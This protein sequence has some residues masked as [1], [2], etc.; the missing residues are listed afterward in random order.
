MKCRSLHIQKYMTEVP[1]TPIAAYVRVNRSRAV[2]QKILLL[3][4]LGL[5]GVVFVVVCISQFAYNATMTSPTDQTQEAVIIP[6]HSADTTTSGN[7]KKQHNTTTSTNSSTQD[8]TGITEHQH[9]IPSVHAASIAESVSSG[10]LPIMAQMVVSP[11]TYPYQDTRFDWLNPD[12]WQWAD[13]SDMG[14]GAAAKFKSDR[15]IVDRTI[16]KTPFRTRRGWSGR[17]IIYTEWIATPQSDTNIWMLNRKINPQFGQGN[18]WPYNGELDLF[19]M[20]TADTALQPHFDFSGFREFS[21][22]ASYGQ[23]TFHMGGKTDGH[24]CFCPASHSKQ[25]WYQNVPSMTSGCTAQFKNTPGQLNRLAAV[26][27]TDNEGQYIQLIQNPEILQ[28]A[29][30]SWDIRIGANSVATQRIKNNAQMFWGI[31]AGECNDG[32]HNPETGF[33]FFE[34]FRFIVEEQADAGRFELHTLKI[35]T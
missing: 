28:G 18:G 9:H 15:I 34:S 20:F 23:M 19:E 4:T 29:D 13:G 22:V 24:P 12:N 11:P 3:V 31:P 35:F 10:N 7:H 17:K 1:S 6:P 25:I 30:D 16:R 5:A 32:D 2:R 8:D 33:P 21:S 27:G 14:R 26:F